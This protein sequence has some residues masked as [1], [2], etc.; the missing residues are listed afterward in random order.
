MISKEPVLFHQPILRVNNR[1]ENID[2]YKKVLGMTCLRE[3]NALTIF[4]AHQNT[5]ARFTIEESPAYRT[6]AVEGAH[7]LQEI[8]LK[9]PS[10]DILALLSQKIEVDSI[11]KGKHYAFRATSP[12]GAHFLV[13]AEEN[14]ADLT[15]ATYPELSTVEDFE[16]VSD[17]SVER[18]TLA[19]P[20]PDVARAF[21]ENIFGGLL[22][23]S[24]VFI[25]AEAP[26]LKV[27][28][29]TTWDLEILEFRVS[30]SYDLVALYQHL[31]DYDL[32]V[33]LDPKQKILVVSDSSR[34]EI[35]IRKW[36]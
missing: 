35:W 19:V 33:Y 7:K 2:F 4:T 14:I 3:E 36:R 16:G 1:Q 23:L 15:Q 8:V 28:P 9:V 22:S 5:K 34:I 31:L 32:E 13:H 20:N 26:D 29:E 30:A 27:S 24:L 12:D 21:Y 18:I 17:F 6:R 25:E 11:L 10:D